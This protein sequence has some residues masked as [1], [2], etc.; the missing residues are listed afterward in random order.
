MSPSKILFFLCISFI[1]GI[2]LESITRVP[3]VFLWAF[4]VFGILL[5]FTSFLFHRWFIIAGF[6]ILFLIFGILRAQISEFNI[7]NNKLSK[8]NGRGEIVLTGIISA[9]PDVRENSQKIK[10][11]TEDSVI[12][13]TTGRYPEYKYLDEIKIT[14]KLE[15][16]METED[17]SY[18]DYLQKDHIYSVMGFPKVEIIGKARGSIVSMAYS[19]TLELKQ[20]LRQR[21]QNNFLPPQSLIL[22][23]IILGDKSAVGQDIK[24]KF[25]ITGLSHVIAV[26]GMHVAILSAIIMSF[27]LFLGLW[28]KQAFCGAVIFI[29]IYVV[30]IG[31]PSSAIRAGIMGII[32]LSGQAIGRQAMSSRIVVLAGALM[33]LF[34]PLLLFYDVGFQLSFL[35]I[36]GLIYLDPLIRSFVK[37]L[38]NRIFK[39]KIS[40]KYENILMM[41]TV[42]ISAQIFTL[43][44]IIYNFGTISFISPITNILVVPILYYLIL[45]G[46]LSSVAGIIWGLFGWLASIPSYFLMTYFLWIIDIFSKPWAYKV[47]SGVS[48]VWIFVFY[49][50]LFFG[51]WFLNKKY[52]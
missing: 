24:D 12:L 16:P 13:V 4:L 47:I 10:V 49:A 44:I 18:K 15:T 33:L 40:E 35:A 31:L 23:G 37:F 52:K 8:L 2:F 27:L 22:R 1:S 45:F 46:F 6:C 5:I 36:M 50:I 7:T 48:W 9:E 11:L 43:P 3:Q 17:F 25:R 29:F 39:K 38:I 32:Y 14:G 42:T 21:I 41:F 34:N 26:S 20:K 30:M 51:I 28:R 19:W